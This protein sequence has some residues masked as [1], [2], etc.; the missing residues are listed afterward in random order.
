MC[1]YVEEK[2]LCFDW[3]IDQI[4]DV[5][6][7]LI[8]CDVCNNEWCNWVEVQF[9]VFGGIICV[10]EYYV[11][12]YVVIDKVSD[13]LECQLCKFKICYM[14]QCQEGCFEFLFGFVEVEVNVQGSGVVMDDVFEFYFEIVCQKCFELCLMFVEDVV[15]QMEVFGYDFYVFQDL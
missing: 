11:D 1:E 15:V 13:V 7:I 5:C 6:V 12:M 2:F 10:E 4:I 8:V 14:K 9:N 3:Y